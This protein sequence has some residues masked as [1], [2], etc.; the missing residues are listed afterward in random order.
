[1]LLLFVFISL[2][3]GQGG[4]AGWEGY[5]SVCAHSGSS[6]GGRTPMQ[7]TVLK[8]TV[9]GGFGAF[10]AWTKHA[11]HR[12][13][14][15]KPESSGDDFGILEDDRCIDR[16]VFQR[17][18][19]VHE[20]LFVVSPGQPCNPDSSRPVRGSRSGPMPPSH[21]VRGPRIFGTESELMTQCCAAPWAPQG[22]HFSK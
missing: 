14:S 10:S 9:S 21:H 15:S 12:P 5:D 3:R 1:M 11:G 8:D 19:L 22:D 4:C 16:G 20:L 17:R 13:G 2:R 7:P 6:N 18:Y